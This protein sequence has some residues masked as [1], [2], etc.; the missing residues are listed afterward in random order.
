MKSLLSSLVC[1]PSSPSSTFA[2][3]QTRSQALEIIRTSFIQEIDERER[4]LK[5]SARSLSPFN[6][7]P[8]ELQVMVLLE[9]LKTYHYLSQRRNRKNQLSVVSKLWM[10]VIL[11]TPGFWTDIDLGQLDRGLKQALD[12]SGALPL[13]VQW[14]INDRHATADEFH[15]ELSRLVGRVSITVPERL[16]SITISAHGFD[17]FSPL[18]K[19]KLPAL[20]R[21]VLENPT[22]KHAPDYPIINISGGPRLRYLH[23]DNAF[24]NF[25]GGDMKALRFLK[26]QEVDVSATQLLSMAEACPALEQLICSDVQPSG[27]CLPLRLKSKKIELV[28][29]RELDV[30]NM[31][32]ALAL[33]FFA[34]LHA[35]NLTQFR[36]KNDT[37]YPL[38]SPTVQKF[39]KKIA[40]LT[41]T[42]TNT[43]PRRI[44]L[45]CTD[46]SARVWYP[47]EGQNRIDINIDFCSD[48]DES[49]LCLL[50]LFPSSEITL[51]SD[52]TIVV[53]ALPNL[54]Y[55]VLPGLITVKIIGIAYSDHAKQIRQLSSFL[56]ALA[57]SVRFCPNLTEIHVNKFPAET[58]TT[59]DQRFSDFMRARKGVKLWVEGVELGERS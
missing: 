32:P 1:Y 17:L 47:G 33:P 52:L 57:A 14:D 50:D 26:F 4:A 7:V 22:N 49:M 48:L 3:I 51:P 40:L 28:S 31:D 11:R 29:L 10:Q 55:V 56:K 34:A 18:L 44:Q 19:A 5:A 15:V 43:S 12:L 41:S 46:K 13:H 30:T 6:R 54:P 59:L 25:R 24:I 8:L 58:T 16:Q 45:S 20:E 27:A 36:W 9:D 37:F 2:L 35:N 39:H 42:V 38:P 21:L 23:T 53:S